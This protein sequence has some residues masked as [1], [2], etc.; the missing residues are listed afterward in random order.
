MATLAA[1]MYYPDLSPYQYWL[2]PTRFSELDLATV[3][4]DGLFE[5]EWTALYFEGPNVSLGWLDAKHPFERSA[6]P[7]TGLWVDRLLE[8]CSKRRIHQTRGFGGCFMCGKADPVLYGGSAEIAV[9]GEGRVFRCPNM[10]GHYVTCG[11]VPPPDFVRA[12]E[13]SADPYPTEAP[14][15]QFDVESLREAFTD[16]ALE[17]ATR[18]YFPAYSSCSLDRFECGP[19]AITIAATWN[20]KPYPQASATWTI[21]RRVFVT[22]FQ[23]SVCIY[24]AVQEWSQIQLG[25]NVPRIRE[26]Q[27]ATSAYRASI[28]GREREVIKE[29][30][31][32]FK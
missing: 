16:E 5:W 17:A 23:A 1:S 2:H 31:K 14:V 30:I 19:E 9:Q 26:S 25:L 11:Y 32:S 6:V 3:P 28:R 8:Y 18:A 4:V 12:F 21:P 20:E 22:L 27:L 7:Q 10:I 13:L 24:G 29:L 15:P